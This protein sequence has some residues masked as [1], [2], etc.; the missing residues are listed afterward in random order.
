MDD[1]YKTQERLIEQLQEEIEARKK[2]EKELREAL[3]RANVV[4]DQAFQFI[5]LLTIDGTMVAVNQAPLSFSGIK[6]AEVLGK[7]FWEAPWF[8]R[9]AA[10]R[11]R[12][13]TSLDI[14]VKGELV[15]FEEWLRD[16][17]GTLRCI[18][19][20]IKPVRDDAGDIIFVIPEGRDITDRKRAAQELRESEERLQA[21]LD[22]SPAV[23]YLKDPDGCYRLINRKFEELFH[24]ERN[25]FLGKT[26]QD[27]VSKEVADKFQM[28]DRA[29]IESGGAIQVEE[30]VTH[31][32][33]LNSY[34]SLK[35]PL[36]DIKGEIYAVCGISSNIT[37]RKKMENV[38]RESE[39]RVR[40]IN[41][42][43]E[44]FAYSVSHDLRAPL[45]S[46]DGFSQILLEDYSDVLDELGK[47][48]LVRAR[49][50]S[51][52]MGKLIDDLL[53]L[54]QLTR[55]EILK[56]RVDLSRLAREIAA[57]LQEDQPEREV[58]FL[59]A[60]E[61]VAEGD[62]AL[63]RVLLKN[64]I[65]NAW[66]FTGRAGRARIEF[67]ALMSAEGGV[68]MEP[69]EPVYFVCDN[70]AGFDMAFQDKLF[71][72][73]QRLHR[74]IDF[75]GTGIGLATVERII[76]QHGGRVWG[77]GVV[78]EGATFFFTLGP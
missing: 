74:A 28:H 70:G 12:I 75:P 67:G 16:K 53:K 54:S 11:D 26:D 25:Q 47:S 18:D 55:G 62:E 69:D 22:N 34:I 52:R 20:S 29:V 38:V 44:A 36:R 7:P 45:R 65:G 60:P 43:L 68:T 66:K 64:L 27:I 15:R 48:Y 4:W 71:G 50:G 49:A 33:G 78:G 42:E 56:R 23:I 32:D 17:R 35:F 24:V 76:R 3:L 46:I 51:Q 19:I 77:K 37:E 10:L 30:E 9:S 31:D 13:R 5:G 39:R 41:K 63:L 14:A 57:E 59:I 40:A 72:A 8:D 1:R 6:K 58:E 2:T 73:F 21:I 61:L